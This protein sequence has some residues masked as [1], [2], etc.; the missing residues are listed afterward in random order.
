MLIVEECVIQ[1]AVGLLQ[2][3]QESTLTMEDAE[4][5]ILEFLVQQ[6]VPEGKAP[7]V[8]KCFNSFGLF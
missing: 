3:I 1:F 4:K 8:R 5:Q 2:Q 6:K 7:L